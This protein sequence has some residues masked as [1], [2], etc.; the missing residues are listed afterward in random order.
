MGY[1]GSLALF[2]D[3]LFKYRRALIFTIFKPGHYKIC[4]ISEEI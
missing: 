3:S 4:R 2:K 1:V